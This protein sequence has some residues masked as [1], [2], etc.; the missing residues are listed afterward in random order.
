M[1]T[2]KWMAKTLERIANGL[3]RQSPLTFEV[4]V[5]GRIGH[6]PVPEVGDMVPGDFTGSGGIG[7]VVIEA[8]RLDAGLGPGHEG[9]SG[10]VAPLLV[11]PRT[12]GSPTDGAPLIMPDGNRS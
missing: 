12:A 11:V 10:S 8:A 5:I 2:T 4:Q 7:F 3:V 1:A 6:A 9:W